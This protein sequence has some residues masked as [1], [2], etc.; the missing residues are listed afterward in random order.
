MT[1]IWPFGYFATVAPHTP[2]YEEKD[3][4]EFVAKE[5]VEDY[6]YTV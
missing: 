3:D 2:A 1:T 6:G 5:A 4:Q